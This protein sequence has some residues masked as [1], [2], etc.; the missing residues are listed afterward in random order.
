MIFASNTFLG[1]SKDSTNEKYVTIKLPLDDI[2]DFFT[3]TDIYQDIHIFEYMNGNR[4]LILGGGSGGLATASRL[5]E[6]LGDKISV[7]VVDKQRSFVLG[8][9]LLRVMTGEKTEQEVTVSKEKVSQKGI[10]FINTEV[11][12]IDLENGIIRTAQGEFAYDYLV[13]ALGAELAPEKVPGFES[14]F[15]MY[16]LED[17][18]KLRNALSSFGG[19]SIRLIVSSTPFKCPPAPYEAA[20]LIDDYLRRKGLR[21][22][23]D[24]QIFTPEPQPMPIAGPEVGNAV[25]SMLNEKG[26]AFHNN[27]KV[28]SINGS[29]KQVVFDNGTREKYDLLVAI[30]PHTSPKV[31]RESDLADAASGW[32][33]VD[34]K[35]MQTKHDR[36]YAIGDVA[37]VKLPSG[38]ML[39]KAATFAF[40]QAEIVA[41]NIASSVLGTEARSW[42]GFGECFIETGSGNA[43]Y[44]SGNFYSMPKPVINLQ[45]PS[46]ELRERKDAWG[47]YWIKRLV[48]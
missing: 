29:S 36:V 15:H 33:P 16:T 28:S 43:G 17:A 25:V 27:T 10:K 34:P 7:T 22:K 18:K 13:I 45:M 14:A 48:A 39:P 6:L 19:G 42:D 30:P 1:D 21:E 24:I 47:N 32:I 41:F 11:D 23:S 9:S 44:G 20:M 8:F 4:V 40:G 35:N 2:L 38:M 12:G 3:A 26:I 31:I 37:A 46:K 5:K